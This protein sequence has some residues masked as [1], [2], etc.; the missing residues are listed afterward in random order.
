[1]KRTISFKRSLATILAIVS[2]LCLLPNATVWANGVEKNGAQDVTPVL[3]AALEK[4]AN[5]VTAPTF[6]TDAGEWT[7]LALARG[8]Y[9]QRCEPYFTE[10]YD[11][12][13]ATVNET[14]AKV[15]MNGAL[16]KSKSTENSRLIVALSALGKDATS[17]GNW[18]LVEAYSANGFNWIKKQGI[19]GTIWAL[20]ALDSNNYATTDATIRQQCVDAIISAQH[21][22]GGWALQANKTY[23]SDP[24]ITSMALQALYSYRNQDAV[25]AA[26][27]KA[28]AWL[29]EAQHEN[30][31]FA[32]DG[33]ECAESCAWVTVACTA[34]GID[35]DTDP[36]FIKNG[37]SVIDGLLRHY[38]EAEKQFAHAV[39]A[40]ANGMATDQS[41]YALVAYSRLTKNKTA[42]FDY[43]D[44][45][46][47]MPHS[48]ATTVTAPTCTEK[49]YTAYVCSYCK[50]SYTDT[51]T[52]ALG[53]TSGE[54]VVEKEASAGVA[55][56]KYKPCT[57]CGEKLET[58]AIEALPND[59]ADTAPEPS[60]AP[61]APIVIAI[62]AIGTAIAVAIVKVYRKR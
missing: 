17:V 39:G 61:I 34:W 11:R 46:F 25:A 62:I 50:N 16:H 14:A 60:S 28:F 41:C 9:F 58:A 32:S 30:G 43:S 31:T 3:N 59:T 33:Y 8:E 36:R 13:I 57:A 45:D 47:T 48:Y 37:N 20:I 22:D 55:G 18:N 44:V 53:H 54:W 1:M 19:N 42:L 7:V 52:D 24:D 15:N 56:S 2:L 5:T 6:G 38:L 21:N 27:E 23:A 51:E 10:Y 26:C 29:S 35:P 40:D 12:I 49:G 4:L